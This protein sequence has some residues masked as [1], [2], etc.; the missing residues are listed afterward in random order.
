MKQF[1]SQLSYPLISSNL[2]AISSGPGNSFFISSGSF[3]CST[4]TVKQNCSCPTSAGSNLPII[5]YYRF[6]FAHVVHNTSLLA[7]ARICQIIKLTTPYIKWQIIKTKIGV[8]AIPFLLSMAKN[9]KA[10]HG[11]TVNAKITITLI[12]PA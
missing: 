5:Y 9:K 10:K 3:S 4:N 1:F 8:M 12:I 2:R 11:R 7:K 6:I